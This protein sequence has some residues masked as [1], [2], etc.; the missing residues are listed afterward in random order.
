MMDFRGHT[1]FIFSI[2]CLPTG[3]IV[4]GGDDC[5]VRLWA[6]GDCKQ[7]IQLPKTVWSVTHDQWGDIIVGTEDKKIRTFTRDTARQDEGPDFTEYNEECKAAAQPG[8][9]QIDLSKI[10]DFKTQIEGRVQ[11]KSDGFVQVF[12][13]DEVAYAYMWS[14]AERKWN[15][16]GEVQG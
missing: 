5:T 11:G 13:E 9:E 7:Q 8:G 16:I 14:N 6:D 1:G 15:K 3:E 2:D 10:P 4:T 12:K